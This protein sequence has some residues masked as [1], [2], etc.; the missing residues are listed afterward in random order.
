MHTMTTIS[1]SF[2]IIQ[3]EPATIDTFR[4]SWPCSNLHD[5]HHIVVAIQGGDLVDLEAYAD[6]DESE[7]IDIESIDGHAL[8]ALVRDAEKN[9]SLVPALPATGRH[10]A[11]AVW[12][13]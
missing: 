9:A 13:Y 2:R 7:P 3:I 12:T 6:D 11:V 8:A 4:E 1:E 5:V 10:Q